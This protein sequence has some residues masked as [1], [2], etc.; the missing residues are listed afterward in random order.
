M[1]TKTISI[2]EEA[3]NRLKTIKEK[4]ESFSD[5][6]LRITSLKKPK[7]SDFYG[8]FSKKEGNELINNIKK[9]REEHLESHEKRMGNLN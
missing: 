5:V 2:K 3:Y 8:I 1:A 7:I 6:I 9:A 4:K